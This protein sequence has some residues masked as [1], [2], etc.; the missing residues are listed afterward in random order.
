[1]RE[2]VEVGADDGVVLVGW[3]RVPEV[4]QAPPVVVMSQGLGGHKEWAL[5]PLEDVLADVGIATL[6]YDHRNF[7]ESGGEPRF[8]VDPQMQIRDCRS[9]VTY[10]GTRAEVDGSR[11]GVFGTS[12]SGGHALVV[13]A[14]DRRVRCI[15][16]Q[17]PTVS[18]WEQAVRRFGHETLARMRE[19]W[20]ADRIQRF[21]GVDPERVPH[22]APDPND[23]LAGRSQNRV[24]FFESLS[25]DELA[26]WKNQ[27]TLRSSE[28]CMEYEPAT[29]IARVSPTPLLMIVAEDD[30]QVGTD[31]Q[32]EAFSRAL[33]PKKLVLTKGGHYDVYRSEFDAAASAARDWFVRWLLEAVG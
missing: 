26:H 20:D 19:R 11:I 17:V 3:L 7:G 5:P 12:L 8:E 4:A 2:K 25:A 27:L 15:V 6:T 28:L 31:L 30:R 22:V 21:N 9:V 14:T 33:E 23:R 10:L 24:S 32:L 1:M 13:G 29:Y 18:G 16:A